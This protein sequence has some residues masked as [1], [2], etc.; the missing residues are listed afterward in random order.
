VPHADAAYNAGRS[1][2]LVAA[3]SQDPSLLFAAT[4]DRLHQEH[5][6]AVYPA[7]LDV[8]S[9]LRESGWA[10]VIS[11]AGPTVLVLT[12]T[13]QEAER[14]ASTVFPGFTA[15]RTHVGQGVAATPD[16]PTLS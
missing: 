3:L 7:S 9:Q 6:R 12:S 15:V 4:E 14:V 13:G 1:A 16:S 5:R 10:A 8:V 11:G 2:L